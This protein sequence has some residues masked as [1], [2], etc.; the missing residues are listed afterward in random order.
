MGCLRCQL[1]REDQFVRQCSCPALVYLPLQTHHS[2][3]QSWIFAETSFCSTRRALGDFIVTWPI[4]LA[5]AR[6][7]PQ[8]RVFYVTTGQK[9][10]LAERA[11]RVE[12]L[13]V[14]SGAWHRL[15]GESPS[16]PPLSAKMLAGAHT[17]FNFGSVPDDRWSQSVQEANA[18][19][20]LVTLRSA[21]PD[22]FAGH[23]TEFLA[24]QLHP[25]P[26]M[27][28]A[29]RQ[30]LRSVAERGIG[31]RNPTASSVL[32]HPGGGAARKCWPAERYLEL[33]GRLRDSGNA[34]CVLLGE[35]ELE[36]WP[37]GQIERFKALA[38]VRTPPTLVELYRQIAAAGAFIGN[39]SGPGHLAGILGVPTLSLF[40]Q[41]SNL[42]RWKPIGP[43]VK[44]V[45]APLESLDVETVF[46]AFEGLGAK[47]IH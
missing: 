29:A 38:E 1:R 3:R 19:A 32:I 45:Q 18:D 33:I 11:L 9:G 10:A 21:A 40:G 20:T 36:S 5:L 26:A 43:N 47:S 2:P 23:Q 37:K 22:D 39:D 12:S 44:G 14:D 31:A 24:D 17:I 28:E 27:A 25:W 8:S 4:A 15:F 46:R 30:V 7:Y 34:V 13:D 6:L 35:V 41:T 42:A 16:L